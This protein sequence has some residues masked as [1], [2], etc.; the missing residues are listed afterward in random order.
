MIKLNDQEL[1]RRE[2]LGY[3]KSINVNPYPKSYDFKDLTL[4]TRLKE[5]FSKISREELESKK[6]FKVKFAGR[7]MAKRG[8]FL[9]LQDTKGQI[10]A[11]YSKKDLE[12]YNNIFEKLD[13]GDIIYVEGIV[14]KTHTNE[15]TIRVS[16]L[17]L[18]TKS[19]K[20]LPEKFHGL[21]DT[22]EKYRKRYLDL[23]MNEESKNRF[24][25]RSK[26]IGLIRDYFNKNDYLEVETPLL[27][28]YLGGASAK[29]FKTHHNA[30]NQDYYL[31]VATE[32]PLK[33]LLVGGIDRVYE[34]GKIFRN[35]GIDTTHNPEFTSIE[36]YEAYSNV[37]GMIEHTEKLIKH[38]CKSLGINS[39][40]F[41]DIEFPLTK[42]F[43]NINMVDEVSKQVGVDFKSVDFEKACE[44]AKKYKIKIEKYFTIG[45]IIN[46]LF[47]EL[48]EHT[49]VEPTFVIGH[50]I[51]IS[52][53]SAKSS[54]ERFTE[55]A[56]L[57]INKKEYANM[58]T[59]LNDPIDQLKRF[60]D[61][62]N[63]AKAGNDEANE[64]DYDFVTA[65]EYGMPPAGGC[66][67]GIDRLIMLLTN[68]DS[69]REVL[70]FPTLK[71][72]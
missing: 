4:S 7:V 50:P 35:E 53:L 44:I 69:I 24:I 37:Y 29:P 70:L 26:V 2:K 64:V 3:Y 45:H 38:I 65:L 9:V 40:K 47:E 63:E 51:E 10:Q 15:V 42:R 22:E 16:L 5:K 52:P 31:R 17:K 33:K 54:D 66:G 71:R 27:H 58:Y 6:P 25:V 18:V 14:M 30:L 20:P 67:I 32:L 49:L 59:E 11:Y 48:V 60:E 12:Q 21:V 8:S 43:N 57:F 28:D 13:L 56:E 72:K 36:F 55:R 34:I 19:L 23:I 62:V 1:V 41:N 68:Q 61:Q 46:A 39:F